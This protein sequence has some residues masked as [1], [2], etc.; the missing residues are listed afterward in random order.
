MLPQGPCVSSTGP[1]W[2]SA[3]PAFIQALTPA[4]VGRHPPGGA[5]GGAPLHSSRLEAPV[6]YLTSAV[7]V[8]RARWVSLLPDGVSLPLFD[9]IMPSSNTCQRMESVHS[10]SAVICW[11]ACDQQPHDR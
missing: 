2:V 1:C 6:S 11:A 5:S 9:V 4:W 10:S 8:R 3:G 7:A